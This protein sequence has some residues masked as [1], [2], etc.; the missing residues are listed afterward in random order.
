MEAVTSCTQMT[1]SGSLQFKDKPLILSSWLFCNYIPSAEVGFPSSVCSFSSFSRFSDMQAL[2]SN[3]C[4]IAGQKSW[5][6]R[7]PRWDPSL[8]LW[9]AKRSEELKHCS[10]ERKTRTSE[11][12]SNAA[13]KHPG[14]HLASFESKF[15]DQHSTTHNQGPIL[16]NI[17]WTSQFMPTS[18]PNLH[19]LNVYMEII[20]LSHELAINYMKNLYSWGP[21]QWKK[22]TF[23]SFYLQLAKL[24]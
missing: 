17:F 13:W 4:I 16:K 23:T 5:N 7:W 20:L 22:L 6:S 1:L 19:K 9:V 8:R 3:C 2:D 15:S 14:A 10:I 21:V 18:S 24:I 11:L 12:E